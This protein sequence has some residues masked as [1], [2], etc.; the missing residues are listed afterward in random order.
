MG[1]LGLVGEKALRKIGALSGGEKVA[2]APRPPP[3][4]APSRFAP[5]LDARRLCPG[6]PPRRRPPR[7]RHRPCARR[8]AWPSRPFA[9]PRATSSSSTS[10]LTTWTYNRST[11][12]S[13]RVA[14]APG[15][16]G[17][18]VMGG[19]KSL[20]ITQLRLCRRGWR[21]G[22]VPT[23]HATICTAT[24]DV[25]T[26]ASQALDSYE[27]AVVV[28]SHD[29]AFCEAVRCTVRHGVSACREARRACTCGS[30]RRAPEH[31]GTARRLRGQRRGLA[32]GAHAAGVR[33]LRG[34]PWRRQR[35]GG[36]A[37]AG[38]YTPQSSSMARAL[39]LTLRAP[40]LGQA[41]RAA[42][43]R[44]PRRSRR[45]APPSSPLTSPD[46]ARPRPTSPD[47][48]RPC[49][50]SPDLARLGGAQAGGEGGA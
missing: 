22:W 27:G 8:R 45:L 16:G 33:L 3:A 30:R 36:H 7:S 9:S 26:P 21:R 31:V 18:T 48:A 40:R 38:L 37:Y 13:R 35:R 4:A 50:T 42:T 49:P 5:P 23:L 28:I 15:M 17:E 47:L 19:A 34:R 43:A 12:C 41:Q 2:T 20:G 25:L 29:R 24:T 6:L 46:L 44:S 14:T 11:R 1:S 32:R 10:L 39:L